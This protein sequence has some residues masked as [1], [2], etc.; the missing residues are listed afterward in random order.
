MNGRETSDIIQDGVFIKA[1]TA[2]CQSENQVCCKKDKPPPT[3]TAD[4]DTC[5]SHKGILNFSLIYIQ[6]INGRP[7][8]WST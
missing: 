3:K 7:L 6:K 1:D 8:N 4:D 5:E 2:E